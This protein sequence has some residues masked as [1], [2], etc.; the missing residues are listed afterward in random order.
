MSKLTIINTE[1]EFKDINLVGSIIQACIINDKYEICSYC[2]IYR[3]L[4]LD[5]GKDI[6]NGFMI[7]GT[8]TNFM[9]SRILDICRL[10]KYNIYIQII[11]DTKKIICYQ[12][13]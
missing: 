7:V 13:Y 10:Y 3:K 2:E 4:L 8:N 1:E 12:N 5:T 9:C 6:N 11:L